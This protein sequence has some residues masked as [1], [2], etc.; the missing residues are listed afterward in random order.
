MRIRSNVFRNISVSL[1]LL[2]I[3][4][5]LIIS[6]SNRNMSIVDSGWKYL[7]ILVIEYALL[8]VFSINSLEFKKWSLVTFLLFPV[9]FTN[10]SVIFSLGV[11][12]YLFNVIINVIFL[13]TIL[14]IGGFITR[15]S[16]NLVDILKLDI[17]NINKNDYRLILPIKEDN[18][19]TGRLLDYLS[20]NQFNEVEMV[21]VKTIIGTVSSLD[22]HANNYNEMYN[23]C[24]DE[25]DVVIRSATLRNNEVEVAESEEGDIVNENLVSEMKSIVDNVK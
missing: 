19:L 23:L 12:M 7:G 2:L 13:F 5:M 17:V 11:S 25:L 9:L 15:N 3:I 14:M 6:V 18:L 1:E 21:K 10:P 8:L 24:L 20:T 16:V 22:K 4:A